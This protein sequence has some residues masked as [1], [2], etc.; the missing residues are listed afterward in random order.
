MQGQVERSGNRSGRAIPVNAAA[1]RRYG[2]SRRE[3]D[4]VC[5][6]KVLHLVSDRSANI[7]QYPWRECRDMI[8]RYVVQRNDL[9]DS[10]G[11][12]DLCKKT[13]SGVGVGLNVIDSHV[14]NAVAP[15][16]LRSAA[17]VGQSVA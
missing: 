15:P 13:S 14:M 4:V 6:R 17:I 1:R 8:N 16:I 7:E 12:G 10:R 9:S 5:N 2:F 3:K 11:R